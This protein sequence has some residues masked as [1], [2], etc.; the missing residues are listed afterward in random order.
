MK[1]AKILL[2][3]ILI[4]AAT[5]AA[6]ATRAKSFFGFIVNAGVYHTVLISFDCPETGKG[7]IYTSWDYA[8]FQV[9][10]LSGI[11]LIPRKP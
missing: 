6:V 3:I 10:T 11:K 2:T 4:M 7:C 1:K 8:T 9:Y 5:G